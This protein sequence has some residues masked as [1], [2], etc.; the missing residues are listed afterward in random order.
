MFLSEKYLTT[1]GLLLNIPITKMRKL[2]PK[3]NEESKRKRN[4]V[5]LGLLLIFIMLFS[6]LGYGFSGRENKNDSG[7]KVKYN[8]YEFAS[9][10]GSWVLTIKETELIFSY[11]PTEVE[12][13][14]SNIKR[15]DNY[16][17]KPLYI[18]SE[19]DMA[20]AEIY[21]AIYRFV[22]RVQPAC[23][24][25]ETCESDELPVKTCEDNFI[26]IKKADD[27]NITQQNNC[28]FIQGTEEEL[29]KVSDEFLFKMFGIEQ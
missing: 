18:S 27:S 26:I 11:N 19:H 9:R 13:S 8:G 21:N 15:L 6:V 24:E 12:K 16:Y 20:G 10:Q 4:Q 17:N 14:N 7:Q 29:L 23:L 25:G 22:Q 5:I 28:V 2:E 1:L 3:Q